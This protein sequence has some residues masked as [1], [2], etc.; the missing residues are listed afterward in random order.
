MVGKLSFL[1][2]SDLSSVVSEFSVS[3]TLTSCSSALDVS[4][5]V[6]HE[7]KSLR[8]S[9]CF[10]YFSPLYLSLLC[11]ALI[12]S[13]HTKLQSTRILQCGYSKSKKLNKP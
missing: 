5:R 8:V 2:A 7:L 9:G 10:S 1:F 6:S 4:G 12:I 11:S 3:R 13:F